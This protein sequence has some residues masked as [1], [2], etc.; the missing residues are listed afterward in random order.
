MQ[1]VIVVGCGIIGAMLAYELTQS[2]LQVTVLDRQPPAQ[3]ATGAA[4]GVLMG[5]ISQKTKGRAWAM[6]QISILRYAELIPEL[7]TALGHALPWNPQGILKL[8]FSEED[9]VKWQA[10]AELRQQQGWR[11]EFWSPDQVMA[12]C[13]QVQPSDLKAGLYSPQDGQIDPTAL[14]LALVEAA[15]RRGACFRFDIEVQRLAANGRLQTSAGELEADW[16]VIA[17]GLGSTPLLPVPQVTLSP[18]LGQAI[19]VK[20]TKPL[21][22]PEFQPIITGQDIHLVPLGSCEY[23]VGATVEFDLAENAPIP[24]PLE[25]VW[26]GAIALWPELAAAVRIS[27]W[28]GLR[29]RPVNRPA[30]IVEP[31]LGYPHVLLATG[32]YRNGV[33]LAPAT[34]QIVRDAIAGSA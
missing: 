19:R 23:W 12:H 3:A 30:P 21:G 16:I 5:V 2:G 9:L 7:E 17:A 15:Q 10:L 6:R 29:P 32:H 11:L 24:E 4:L 13:P 25:E 18:V 1:Q 31:L 8:G 20:T 26:Q 28:S 34:A 27:S 22:K 33:L 14:T